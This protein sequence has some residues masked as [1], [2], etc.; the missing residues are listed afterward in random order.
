MRQ[1]EACSLP[2]L[3]E[4]NQFLTITGVSACGKDYL[5]KQATDRTLISPQVS[6][7]SLGEE[8]FRELQ[9]AHPELNTR[10]DIKR[11]LTQEQ[12]KAGVHQLCDKLIAAQPA[13]LNTHVVYRQ[14]DSL[15]FNPDVERR[16]NPTGYVYVWADP[17]QISQWRAADPRR[18]RPVETVDEIALHQE[19]AIEITRTIATFNGA[20]MTTIYNR[21]DN[22]DQN[23]ETLS[24]AINQLSIPYMTNGRDCGIPNRL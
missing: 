1:K 21:A 17:E 19:L 5:L 23:V 24:Q 7:I 12:V 10:D 11:L 8:L 14:G 16:L 6:L 9:L 22:L 2:E 4:H 18:N 13:V 15:T 3:P 20:D